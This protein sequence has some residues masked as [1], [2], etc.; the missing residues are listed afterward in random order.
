M[1]VSL[2]PDAALPGT[3]SGAGTALPARPAAWLEA[4]PDDLRYW[5]GLAYDTYTGRAWRNSDAVRLPPPPSETGGRLAS[6]AP[7]GGAPPVVLRFALAP[8]PGDLLYAPGEPLRLSVP[9]LLQSRSRDLA[10]ADHSA[11]RARGPGVRGRAYEATVPSTSP[12]AD[13]LRRPGRPP[14]WR[15]SPRDW[16]RW[17]RC[18]SW[19]RKAPWTISPWPSRRQPPLSSTPAPGLWAG[20]PGSPPA[21]GRPCASWPL[22]GTPGGGPCTGPGRPAGRFSCTPRRPTCVSSSQ[23]AQEPV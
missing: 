2:A 16:T 11:R 20:P 19:P 9:Y 7:A 18:T 12:S 3:P 17:A 15:L 8:A 6:P 22:M 23:D 13:D 5:R 1:R 10:P 14:S 4:L 21:A